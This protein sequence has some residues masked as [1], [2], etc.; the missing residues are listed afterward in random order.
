MNQ[1]L[2][3]ET[4]I[5]LAILYSSIDKHCNSEYILNDSTRNINKFESQTQHLM[6]DELMECDDDDAD[7]HPD[8][9][10]CKSFDISDTQ[11]DVSFNE[12][13][14]GVNET[15]II[16][17][18]SLQPDLE[19]NPVVVK[20]KLNSDALN[21]ILFNE[22]DEDITKL[23]NKSITFD[24]VL[25]TQEKIIKQTNNDL[26]NNKSVKENISSISLKSQDKSI[27]LTNQLIDSPLKSS[28]KTKTIFASSYKKVKQESTI[29]LTN[30]SEMETQHEKLPSKIYSKKNPPKESLLIKTQVFLIF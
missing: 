1:R 18:D 7:Y 12:S 14:K 21:P 25:K 30:I 23:T 4:E 15:R 16:I 17:P 3:D 11:V 13:K 27:K 22:K 28:S 29:P 8:E 5:G 20:P 10:K 24:C 26:S 19:F 2:I 6:P 9:K